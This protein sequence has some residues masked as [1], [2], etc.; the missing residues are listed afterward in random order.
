[1]ISVPDEAL[2]PHQKIREEAVMRDFGGRVRGGVSAAVDIGY[3]GFVDKCVDQA[4]IIGDRIDHQR[5]AQWHK[6]VGTGPRRDPHTWERQLGVELVDIGGVQQMHGG[7]QH[8][9]AVPRSAT[10]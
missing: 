7:T 5:M 2:S 9:R 6:A 4:P 8:R 10:T 3:R 1:M